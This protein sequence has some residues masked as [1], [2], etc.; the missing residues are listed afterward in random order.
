MASPLTS[1]I[2]PTPIIR[3][4]PPQPRPAPDQGMESIGPAAG[5]CSC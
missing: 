4:S 1:L 5:T 2:S 3:S